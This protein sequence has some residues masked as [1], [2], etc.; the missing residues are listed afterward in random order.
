MIWRVDIAFLERADW[1]YEP[2]TAGA[3]GGGRI[4]TFGL[5]SP[6]KKLR[7]AAAYV[8]PRVVLRGGRPVLTEG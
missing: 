7:A 1:K 2:S 5:Q 4:H 6:A 8:Y 3:S